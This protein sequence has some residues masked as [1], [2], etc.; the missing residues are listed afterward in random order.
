MSFRN[1]LA[2]LILFAAC[3]AGCGTCATVTADHKYTL[4][5]GMIYGGIVFIAL[6]IVAGLT[7][8]R[9]E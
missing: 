9:K 4:D 3:F 2:G 5:Q 1:I 6:A 8:S 7:K